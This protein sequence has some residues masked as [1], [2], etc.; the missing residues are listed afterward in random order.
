MAAFDLAKFT[1][2]VLRFYTEQIAEKMPDVHCYLLSEAQLIE[3]VNKC[4]WRQVR[5]FSLNRSS[6]VVD[7]PPDAEHV[8]HGLS[9]LV[10]NG[11][12]EELEKQSKTRR[13]LVLGN[14]RVVHKK[15]ALALTLERARRYEAV[16]E[17][18]RIIGQLHTP[19]G[20][21]EYTA[22]A[23]WTLVVSDITGREKFASSAVT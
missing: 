3:Y 18:F 4:G 17:W 6:F 9:D 10:A 1:D 8:A 21:T 7:D 23:E 14:F 19:S 22:F 20:V 13:K 15:V 5:P 16:N 12:R 2:D 11:V